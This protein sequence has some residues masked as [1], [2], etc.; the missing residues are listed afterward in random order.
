MDPFCR[1]RLLVGDRGMVALAEARVLIVGLGGVGS[2]VAEALAR[3]PVGHFVLVDRDVV[4]ASN[5][6]RQLAALRSTIG[7]PKAA[8]M[9]DR[10]LDLRPAADVVSRRE[11]LTPGNADEWAG[12]GWDCVVDAIDESDP[13]VALLAA[14]VRRGVP[15]VSSMGAACRLRPEAIRTADISRTRNCPLA[16]TLRKRL[17][18]MGIGRGVTAVYSEELPVRLA[19]TGAFQ[20]ERADGEGE[21]RPQGTVSYMPALFGFH[22]AAAVVQHLLRDIRFARRGDGHSDERHHG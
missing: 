16:R 13:K 7:R 2:H 6:N 17:R 1:T 9:R 15:V 14:C 18:R 20:A 21:K 5:F 10:I 4:V 11:A 12:G 22:C 3:A 8:V 19:D